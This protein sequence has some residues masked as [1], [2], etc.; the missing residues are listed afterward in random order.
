MSCLQII[1]DMD[2][3]DIINFSDEEEQRY[4]S[5]KDIHTDPLR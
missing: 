1:E 2:I 3:D 4:K 5:F